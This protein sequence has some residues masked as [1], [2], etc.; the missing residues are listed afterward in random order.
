MSSI[1][2]F[3]KQREKVL[4]EIKKIEKLEGVENESN[5]L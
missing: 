4:E 2:M 5:S 1:E 3:E